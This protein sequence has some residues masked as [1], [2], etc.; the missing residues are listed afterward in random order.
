MTKTQPKRAQY[1]REIVYSKEHWK[2]LFSLREIAKSVM[3]K[4]ENNKLRPCL[5]GSVA[6]GDINEKSD[7][8]IFVDHPVDEVLMKDILNPIELELVQGTRLLTPR[9]VYHLDERTKVTVPICRFSRNEIDFL[10][11]AG[12][13][14]LDGLTEGKRVPGVNK[15]LLLIQPTSDGHTE[16]SIIG[17]E[18]DVA[19]L[20]GINVDTI[21]ERIAVLIQRA[22]KGRSGV[23]LR[24]FMPP[25]ESA[26]MRYIEE[27]KKNPLLR[28]F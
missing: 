2:L 11:Y 16:E 15:S 18:N 6:R 14:Q 12:S 22:E 3:K 13:L 7:I 1:F 20:L 19:K 5:I 25:T 27:I 4:L 8:D 21:R 28:T 10:R 23:L 9:I 17:K 24:I 26:T